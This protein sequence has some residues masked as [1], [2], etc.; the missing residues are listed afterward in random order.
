[1]SPS[2]L[3]V[4]SEQL[5]MKLQQEANKDDKDANSGIS[6]GTHDGFDLEPP[7]AAAAAAS[8]AAA[9]AAQD[10]SPSQVR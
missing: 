9:A 5:A 2:L 3:E 8:A 6:G 10:F 4:Q 7:T 1:M